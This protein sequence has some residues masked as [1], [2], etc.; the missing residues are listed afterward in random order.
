[1]MFLSGTFFPV[2]QF[3][4]PLQAFAH[5]LPLYYVIDGLEGIML[6]NNVG[7]AL[8]DLGVVAVLAAV[9]FIAAI[10]AFRWRAE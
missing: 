2:S 1:M 8:V 6:F 10:V 5:V 3:S 9:I 7:R 4:P